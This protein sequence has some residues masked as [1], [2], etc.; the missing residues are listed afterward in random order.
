MS[1][2]KLAKFEALKDQL[3]KLELDPELQNEIKKREEIAKAGKALGVAND[4]DLAE[5]L[6][7][8]LS[9]AKSSL[10]VKGLGAS[11]SQDNR[12]IMLYLDLKH[13]EKRVKERLLSLED[14]PAI[15][16]RQALLKETEGLG[17]T[18]VEAA[19]LVAPTRMDTLLKS[20]HKQKKEKQAP[21]VPKTRRPLSY[22]RNPKTGEVIAA[23]SAGRIE[24]KRWANEHGDHIYDDWKISE[25]EF[26]ALNENK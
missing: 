4:D 9:G 22:W 26:M 20:R 2:T 6:V 5:I 24:L 8:G 14:D 12:K 1:S 21:Y 18:P 7:P 11:P 3:Q 23:R 15:K 25:E 10:I 17:L 13:L 19:T 16:T